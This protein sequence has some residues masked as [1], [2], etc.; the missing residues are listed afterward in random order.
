M[1]AAAA[2]IGLQRGA[3][4]RLARGRLV[5]EQR[6]RAHHHAGNAVAALRSLQL[7]ERA[8]HRPGL[9]RGAETL[10]RGDAPAPH[11]RD[12]RD[13]GEDRLAVGEHGAGA[14]LPEPAAELGGIELEVLA[15]HIE[16]RRRR[17]GVDLVRAPIDIELHWS[18]REMLRT[19]RATSG[20][21]G[22]PLSARR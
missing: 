21:A 13:A 14:A 4:L 10:E 9:F 3:N 6:L 5:L 12:R 7:D 18:P 20:Q 15:Q 11:D 19:S 22:R 2:E 1:R 8:L 16:E 17:I